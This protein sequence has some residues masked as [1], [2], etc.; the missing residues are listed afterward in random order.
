MA[1][2]PEDPTEHLLE[3]ALHALAAEAGAVN[4][5]V[6]DGDEALA[7]DV[8]A[9]PSPSS[10]RWSAVGLEIERMLALVKAAKSRVRNLVRDRERPFFL[11]SPFGERHVLLVWF[12][13]PFD[14]AFIEELVRERLAEIERL[15]A[16][17]P[18]PD[19][20]VLAATLRG[21]PITRH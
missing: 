5:F 11:A 20:E 13:H 3:R 1:I 9:L 4:A 16:A 21:L 8:D 14:A 19:L 15:T 7:C 2:P 10:P 12:E 18:P 6:S 17:L